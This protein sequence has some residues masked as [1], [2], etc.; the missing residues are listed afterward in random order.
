M[1]KIEDV[2]RLHVRGLATRRIS[3][4]TGVGKTTVIEYLR[5]AGT[6]GV[7]WPLP[8]GLDEAELERLLFPPPPSKGRRI[9]EPDWAEIHRELKRPGVT[10]ALLWDEYRGQHSDG[11]GY[12]AFC[13]HS[14]R[15]AGR[16]SPVMRQRHAA[17]ERMFVDYSGT[18]MAV[19]DPATGAPRPAEIFIAVMGASNQT[20]AEAS[21]SQTLPDWIG[22]HTRAFGFFGAVP[23]LVVSDNLKSG[24]IR[25]CFYEPEVNRSYAEMA[26]HYGTAIL[27]ARPYKPRDK[28]KVEVAVLLVQRWI[29]ARLRNRQFFTLEE[30]NAAIREEVARLNARV[31]RHLGAA[32]QEL[33]ETIDRP[34]MQPLPPEPFVHADWRKASVGPD[35]HLRLEGHCYSVPHELIRRQLW[36]RLTAATVEI[37]RG[38]KRVA[39]HRR[40]APG[41]MGATTL[42]DHMPASHRRHAEVTPQMLRERAGRIGPATAILVDVIL[43]D[44]PHPEQGFR[45]CLGILRLARSH[46][47]ERL[48][49]ACDRALAINARTMTSV[50]SILQNR[51][52]GRPPDRPP[53]APPITH[54]NIR[55]PKF[56]H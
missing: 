9:P 16:L 18:R 31:S 12:S 43:R 32:R 21:W 7:S 29:I 2:L 52:E 48:E 40:A 24:V 33:F 13:E 41:D 45:S 47:A 14:R 17:G 46:G 30:L 4:A 25:A 28:A 22:A 10:L 20:Y 26:A 53:E 42:N 34:A 44:R 19:I 37:F 1:R 36:A 27:P 5:R 51:L 6:A 15:W 50:K 54:A 3:L 35:Y 56:F 8:E 55:G 39:C 11:Y 49:A 23:A 38:G